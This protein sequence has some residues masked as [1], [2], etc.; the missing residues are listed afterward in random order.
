MINLRDILRRVRKHNLALGTLQALLCLD[1]GECYITKIAKEI[2]ITGAATTG[3]IDQLVK[4][5][6]VSRIHDAE[7][8]RKIVIKLTNKGQGYLET[9]LEGENA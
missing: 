7:D 9:I 6:L 5:K 8:R 2:G 3:I 1:K 4:Q